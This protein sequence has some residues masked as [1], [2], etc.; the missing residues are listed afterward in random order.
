MVFTWVFTCATYEESSGWRRLLIV[1]A[2]HRVNGGMPE[3]GRRN[4]DNAPRKR[5]DRADGPATISCP[6][7]RAPEYA[8][9][10]E[11]LRAI[12]EHRNRAR[13]SGRPLPI[14]PGTP[15]SEQ[16][17]TAIGAWSAS[18]EHPQADHARSPRAASRAG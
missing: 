7:P 16:T 15:G 2:D 9:N 17:G 18:A 6:S 1:G 8:R 11:S 14:S 4:C 5:P 13:R 3:L 12:L 10:I